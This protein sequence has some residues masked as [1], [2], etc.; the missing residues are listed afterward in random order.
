MEEQ[1]PINIGEETHIATRHNMSLF[2]FLG[3]NAFADHVF[4]QL[5]E[6]EENRARGLYI[7]RGFQVFEPL[8]QFIIDNRFP[9]HLNA[10]EVPECDMTAWSNYH[11]A[12]IEAA[13]SY[14]EDWD[15]GDA[16]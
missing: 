11:Y 12:D 8:R 14:P 9:M 3:E 13:D 16:A 5:E 1:L 7:F 2:T 10:T 6:T 15:K 4:L